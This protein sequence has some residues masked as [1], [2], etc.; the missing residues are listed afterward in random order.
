MNTTL[1]IA[2]L[3]VLVISGVFSMF[4]KGG[5]WEGLEPGQ[6]SQAAHSHGKN[7]PSTNP[8]TREPIP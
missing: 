1:L 6:S 4:D 3:V 7:H 5:G 8:K 2:F